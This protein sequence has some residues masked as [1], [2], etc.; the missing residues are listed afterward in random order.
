MK[1]PSKQIA[2]FA[3]I[4][5]LMRGS[6]RLPVLT[7]LS[8]QPSSSLASYIISNFIDR[9]INPIALSPESSPLMPSQHNLFITY[10]S[11]RLHSITS[12]RNSKRQRNMEHMASFLARKC[13]IIY[14]PSKQ[15]QI[16]G[17]YTR[18]PYKMCLIYGGNQ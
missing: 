7:L 3:Q 1:F 6:M 2:F 11:Q 17:I 15:I 10:F 8:S 18:F 14:K 5:W 12:F 4:L 9:Y 16:K 13:I